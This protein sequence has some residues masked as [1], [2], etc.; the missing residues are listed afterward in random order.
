MASVPVALI[1]FVAFSQEK[2][3]GSKYQRALYELDKA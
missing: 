3:T 1:E 2:S